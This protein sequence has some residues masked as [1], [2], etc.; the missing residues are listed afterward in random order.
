MKLSP[1]NRHALPSRSRNPAEPSLQILCASGEREGA[2]MTGIASVGKR[3]SHLTS[4]CN[5][6]CMRAG[7]PS[8]SMAQAR[9]Y[10]C[11][12]TSVRARIPNGLPIP[13]CVFQMSLILTADICRSS[14][15]IAPTARNSK[16]F[17]NSM[18]VLCVSTV[19]SLPSACLPRMLSAGRA[20]DEGVPSQ[21]DHLQ[22]GR[23][24]PGFGFV[25]LL[26]FEPETQS[27]VV[28]LGLVLPKLGRKL[29][30]NLKVIE[31]QIDFRSF[32][33]EISAHVFFPNSKGGHFVSAMK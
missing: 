28:N 3:E 32:P 13:V 20:K 11:P 21:S 8:G 9:V 31:P 4:S 6:A 26:P 7:C 18:W 12:K 19:A 27:P 1:K 25:P 14:F 15:S 23:G 30:S 5:V 16:S 17:D 29:A 33:S 10:L 22:C 2:M 24:A